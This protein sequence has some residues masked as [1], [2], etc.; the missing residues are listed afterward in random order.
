MVPSIFCLQH[1]V[2]FT[3]LHNC[4]HIPSSEHSQRKTETP[5]P[6]TLMHPS[7]PTSA[8]NSSLF[9]VSV[10][11]VTL[12]TSYSRN[13]ALVPLV[14]RLFYLVYVHRGYLHHIACVRIFLCVVVVV[15]YVCTHTC[16]CVC[17]CMWVCGPGCGGQ[18]EVNSVFLYVHLVFWDKICYWV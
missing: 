11:L 9:S 3:L 13:P 15:L 14:I 8:G 6:S 5:P 7:S 16:A 12:R 10:N 18:T 17:L 1:W 2:H 4:P